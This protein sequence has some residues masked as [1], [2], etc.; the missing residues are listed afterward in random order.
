MPELVEKR[1]VLRFPVTLPFLF[2]PNAP[3]PVKSGTGWTHDLS[4]EGACLELPSRFPKASTM[5]ILF[6]TDRGGLDLGAVVIW[7]A[8]LQ[9][10]G[11]GVLHGVS[12]PDLTPDQRQTLRDLL[13]AE[14]PAD[15]P[16]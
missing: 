3:T 11:E 13:R 8:M 14:R 5:R 6:Q 2:K 4:E 1:S 9:Q 12:F 10:K 16:S 15:K 7:T